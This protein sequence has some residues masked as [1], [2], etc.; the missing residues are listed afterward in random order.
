MK[1]IKNQ[2]GFTLVEM[3]VV[4]V[5]LGIIAGAAVPAY[6][7]LQTDAQAANN[8]AYVGAL[9][10][11]LGMRFGQQLVRQGDTAPASTDVIGT[12]TTSNATQVY[13]DSLVSTPIPSTLTATSGICG[14]GQWVGLAPG[15][16]PANAT[17]A[18]TCGAGNTDPLT[19]S[20]P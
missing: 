3:I 2:K 15:N 11:A 19:I 16:P 13:L 20:G 1:N 6:I 9:R 14:T 17:W 5:I 18:I 8:M 7:N 4:I 12:A 10:S